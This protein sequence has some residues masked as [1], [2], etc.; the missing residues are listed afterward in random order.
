[1]LFLS[2]FLS[3]LLSPDE[4]GSLRKDTQLLHERNFFFL[5]TGVMRTLQDVRLIDDPFR[6]LALFDVRKDA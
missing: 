6:T 4:E 2:D 5:K 3:Q 1:M